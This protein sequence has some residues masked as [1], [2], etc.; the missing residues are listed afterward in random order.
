MNWIKKIKQKAKNLALATAFTTLSLLTAGEIKGQIYDNWRPPFPQF[1]GKVNMH[2]SPDETAQYI[3]LDTKTKRN[4]SL[5]DAIDSDWVNTMPYIFPIWM[6]SHYSQQLVINSINLGDSIYT[7]TGLMFGGYKGYNQDSIIMYGGTLADNGKLQVPLW[8]VVFSDSITIPLGHAMNWA[9]T[10][11]SLKNPKDLN[12]IE[13]QRDKS[14]VHPGEEIM[15][16][17]CKV[18]LLY[19]TY[20]RKELG[21]INENTFHQIPIALYTIKEGILEFVETNPY[22][23][24]IL[25][26]ERDTI[27]PQ[28]AIMT[29]DGE[30][31]GWRGIDENLKEI[32]MKID[33]G[34]KTPTDSIGAIALKDLGAPGST[35]K[36]VFLTKD[37]FFLTGKDSI[38]VTVPQEPI[39]VDTTKPVVNVYMNATA[40]TIN[41][42]ITE[43]HFKNAFYNID[44]NAQ[45]P[46]A[47]TGKIATNNLELPD[48]NHKITFY[49]NDST[50]NTGNGSTYFT[51]SHTG[52]EE[53]TLDNIV[54]YP[55][56][57]RDYINLKIND[58]QATKAYVEIYSLDGRLQDNQ[59]L[60]FYGNTEEQIDLTKLK[61][62]M[63]IM[64]TAIGDKILYMKL[65][66]TE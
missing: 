64:K 45:T 49:A 8:R 53:K 9:I 23:E 34:T 39:E 30:S 40:D 20:S 38:N 19:Y 37:Y 13:P 12:F 59:V 21:D 28:T 61:P 32:Y 60:E 52:I 26:T 17:N 29:T 2:L 44:N 10:G 25:I 63:F 11:K 31:L 24:G 55:N 14:N 22:L 36:V 66:R 58:R 57:A 1:E 50:N 5:Q 51:T 47:Q 48:G 62:S 35:H 42:N 56:P 33:D 6:C 43:E 54:L 46:G 7:S 27:P 41:W 16:Y 4:N 65:I 15:P 18:V 3:M